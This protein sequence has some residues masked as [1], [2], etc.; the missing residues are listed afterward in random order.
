M[1]PPAR[2]S[3][4]LRDKKSPYING[5]HFTLSV[6]VGEGVLPLTVDSFVI[7]TSNPSLRADVQI[8]TL[9]VDVQ[10]RY[11][12][13]FSSVA[14]EGVF[15]ISLPSE[16]VKDASGNTA[17]ASA[18]LNVT[19]DKTKPVPSMRFLTPGKRSLEVP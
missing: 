10:G 14:G 16:S 9:D 18:T 13:V 2:P 11:E 12:L 5:D 6:V 4:S 3:V 7:K 1:T 8:I 19:I 15:L 17:P